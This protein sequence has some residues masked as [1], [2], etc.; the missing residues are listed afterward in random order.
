M[1]WIGK[2]RHFDHGR[3]RPNLAKDFLVG[4]SDLGLRG[5]VGDV[6]PRADDLLRCRTAASSASS[7]ILKAANVWRY[8]SPGCST[9]SRPVAVVPA[10]MAQSPATTTRE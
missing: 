1:G 7:A 8:G 4:A 2:P 3:H 6:Q 5:D 9:P 10:V